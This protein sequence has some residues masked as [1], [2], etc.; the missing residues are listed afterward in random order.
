MGGGHFRSYDGH[1]FD[2]N[3]GSCRYVL[4]QVCEEDESHPTVIIQQGQLHLRVH[5]VNISLE[6]EHLGKVKCVPGVLWYFIRYPLPMGYEGCQCESGYM[7]SGNGCVKAE[8]CGCFYLGH[9]YEIGELS[10]DEGCSERCN[11]SATATMRCDPASCPE[12]ETCTL[13]NT[14]GCAREDKICENGV[15]CGVQSQPLQTQ[16][17]VL[18]GAHFYTFDGKVFEF[19]GNCTYT[20]IHISNDTSENITFWVGVQKDRNPNESSS[21]K[22][23]VKVAKDTSITIY[24]GGKGYALINGEKRLLPVTLQFG[25]GEAVD[26]ATF[27]WNWRVSDQE[28]RC[29]ADCG[30]ACPRC[31]S[32]QLLEKNVASQWI[33]MHEYIWSPQ[34]PLYLCLEVNY[35]K[36]SAAVSLFDLCSTDDTQKVLCLV[37]EAYAAACQ[38]AQIQIGEW[39]NSTFCLFPPIL[40]ILI[41]SISCFLPTE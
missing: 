23:H 5:G 27:G 36:I 31:S 19:Q 13:N 11:C 29:T 26:A 16:C 28:A 33:A 8:Q 2:F 20:L 15:N 12:G 1:S 37:L 32:E 41:L 7:R 35:A 30:D 6:M 40:L 39:R 24:R 21:L 18:G 3:M 17:W 25:L 38:N 22:A 9:Y 10:W 34:N 14:W 4:S